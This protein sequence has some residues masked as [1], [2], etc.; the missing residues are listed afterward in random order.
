MPRVGFSG[1]VSVWLGSV[2]SSLVIVSLTESAKPVKEKTTAGTKKRG[3]PESD[4]R[5]VG[6]RDD[7]L[8]LSVLVGPAGPEG[9]GCASALGSP[10]QSATACTQ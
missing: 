3:P 8:Q 9:F 10:Q 7:L 5:A 2:C 4:P 6:G 1:C